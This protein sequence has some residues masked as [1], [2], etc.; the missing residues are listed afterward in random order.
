ML[1][2]SVALLVVVALVLVG[3]W[4]AGLLPSWLIRLLPGAASGPTV[5]TDIHGLRP[6]TG[7]RVIDG[8]TL[9]VRLGGKTVRVRLLNIDA[10]E[11]AHDDEPGQCLAD[12]AAR[13]LRRLAGKGSDLRLDVH[14]KDRFG[15]TLAGVYTDRG[16]LVNSEIVRAGLAAP[17]VVAGQVDL[18]EPVRAAQHAAAVELLGLHAR[19]GCT[20][21]G[22]LASVE[23]VLNGVPMQASGKAAARTWLQKANAASDEIGELAT[24]MDGAERNALVDG[25]TSVQ[26]TDLK[27]RLAIARG[28]VDMIV[29]A[30]QTQA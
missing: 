27:A 16:V 8:D 17:L 9:D 14:G 23:A 15:R 19:Q 12:E 3:L 25:L 18:I 24:A 29:A 22:R 10:P 4:T 6:A 7:V 20:I 5:R 21:G 11:A 13:E 28:R 2:R 26:Q 30:L 1:R